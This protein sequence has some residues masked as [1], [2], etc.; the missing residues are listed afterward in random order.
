MGLLVVEAGG[1]AEGRVGLPVQLFKG[2][3]LLFVFGEVA[4]DGK[5]IIKLR[6]RNQR[7]VCPTN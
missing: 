6:R 7:R 2:E 5:L 1:A 3:E 4:W